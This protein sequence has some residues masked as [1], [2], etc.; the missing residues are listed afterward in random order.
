MQAIIFTEAGSGFGLG[1]LSRCDALKDYLENAGFEV[2]I[3]CRG[4]YISQYCKQMEWISDDY[5]NLDEIINNKLVV[6]DSYYANKELC[7]YIKN[8]AKVCVFFDDFNRIDYPQDSILLNGGLLGDRFYRNDIKN[9]IFAGIEYYILRKEFR[10]RE[11]KI[12]NKDISRI[13][14]TLGGNDY[15]NNTQSILEIME[16]ECP[17]AMIDV[18]LGKIHKP[19]SYNFHTSMHKNLSPRVLKNLML[20]CDLAISGGGVTMVELQSTCTPTIAMQI[21]PNQAYQL[22]VWQ[23]EG[24]R[25]ATN[26]HQIKGLLKTLRKFKDRKKLSNKLAKVEIGGK[27]N[28]FI[29][30]LITR[31]NA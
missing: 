29:N 30:T 9:E 26:I 18:V 10:Q 23:K 11:Q 7:E 13:L 6:V 28:E 4:D 5:S 25:I 17:Y 24:L 22:R 12:I 1:H 31:Y 27:I 2:S 3:Y 21:A 8:K 16:K 14:I 19:I 20:D 15:A